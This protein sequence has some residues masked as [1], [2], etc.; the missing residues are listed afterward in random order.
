MKISELLKLTIGELEQQVSMP[1]QP[2]GLL[3][4]LN[5][6]GERL[7][8]VHDEL[9]EL[10]KFVPLEV[11]ANSND[12]QIDFDSLGIGDLV[13]QSELIGAIYRSG[14]DVKSRE[15]F[16]RKQFALARQIVGRFEKFSAPLA[17]LR[18][19]RKAKKDGQWLINS[20]RR[21]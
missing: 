19:A 21:P 18:T 10:E 16:V 1:G 9:L 13:E 11:Q 15:V 6:F 14:V 8:S 12:K 7:Q 2:E 4:K 20:A 3:S 5:D 17:L